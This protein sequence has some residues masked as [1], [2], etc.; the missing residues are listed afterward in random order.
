[1]VTTG[2][3]KEFEGLDVIYVEVQNSDPGH[4]Y[5]HGKGSYFSC[6]AQGNCQ[7]TDLPKP[8]TRFPVA[9]VEG[10]PVLDFQRAI[11]LAYSNGADFALYYCLTKN[12]C[13]CWEP[14]GIYS[15]GG[16][17]DGTAMYYDPETGDPWPSVRMMHWHIAQQA[18]EKSIMDIRPLPTCDQRLS[19]GNY[20]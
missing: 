16:N 3:Q 12:I 17:G 8:R 5:E 7:N 6:M 11:H 13:R 15:E 20:R 1:M 19:K 14:G 4:S 18:V 9:V 2:P 10:D